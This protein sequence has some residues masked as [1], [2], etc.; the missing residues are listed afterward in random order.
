MKFKIFLCCVVLHTVTFGQ[1]SSANEVLELLDRN[2]FSANMEYDMEMS[3]Y[4]K[5]KVKR[6]Y[7]MHV[8]KKDDKLRLEIVK[9]NIEKDRRIL[10]DGDNLWMYL[11]RSSKLIK[12]PYKQAFLG[13]DASNRDILRVSLVDDY[14]VTKMETNNETQ[15]L[16]LEAND[17]SVSYNKVIF[18]LNRENFAPIKQEMQSLSGKTIKTINYEDIEVIDGKYIPTRFTIVDAL[19]GDTKTVFLYSNLLLEVHQ[20]DVFFTTGSLSK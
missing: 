4:K 6:S 19:Q 1:Q 3:I 12:I 10:N 8:F 7:F 16:Y 18:Y 2:F 13:G 17:L 5:E 9:P 15:I 20:P 14:K 11:P